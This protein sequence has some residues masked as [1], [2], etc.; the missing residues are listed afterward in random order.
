M[1]LRVNLKK[2][3]GRSVKGQFPVLLDKRQM[4]VTFDKEEETFG[5]VSPLTLL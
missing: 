3:V 1:Q 4:G 5:L 2:I